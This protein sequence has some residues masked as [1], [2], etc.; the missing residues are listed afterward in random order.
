MK[1]ALEIS[2]RVALLAALFAIICGLASLVACRRSAALGI[3]DLR[4]GTG[5][6]ARFG[7]KVA[8]HYTAR[9]KDGAQVD[10]SRA[11]G[12]STEFVIG[13]GMVVPG[14]EQGVVGMRAG[15]LRR[16]TVPPALAYGQRAG[17]PTIP[18]G[19]TLI[20][21]VELIAVM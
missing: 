1:R 14:F 18:S 16:I 9:L 8:V 12:K 6:E 5:P 21:D 15:G 17:G 10:D 3:E 4:I 2:A 20:F 11:R 7:N 19:S 13:H